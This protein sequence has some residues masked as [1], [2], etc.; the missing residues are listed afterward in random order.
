MIGLLGLFGVTLIWQG[1]RLMTLEPS[2]TDLPDY[3]A[4][5]E[6][7]DWNEYAKISGAMSELT[8]GWVYP[9][10]S[11]QKKEKISIFQQKI[12]EESLSAQTNQIKLLFTEE[13][14]FRKAELENALELYRNK[15]HLEME[16]ELQEQTIRIKTNFEKEVTVRELAIKNTVT[17]YNEE[18]AAKYQVTLANLQLQLLLIDLSNRIK[19]PALEKQRIQG[20]IDK[21][22]QEMYDK[23]SI[24]QQ[25]LSEELAQY[26]KQ[27][28]ISLDSEIAGIRNKLANTA[29]SAFNKYRERLE[30]DFYQWQQ[31]RQQDIEMVIDL[32]ESRL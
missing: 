10:S 22:H 19:E 8:G 21:V 27:R 12:A 20:Q 14:A 11:S 15:L 13:E 23:I 2:V 9:K 29:E 17:Q 24:R 6:R 25:Q 7:A 26:K 30:A 1:Y 32:R 16:R 4:N 28:Q 3:A 18:M 31:Q 5:L